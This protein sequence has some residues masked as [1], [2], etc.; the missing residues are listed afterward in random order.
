MGENRTAGDL[1]DPG[2]EDA[3]LARTLREQLGLIGSLLADEPAPGRVAGPTSAGAAATDGPGTDV[4]EPQPLPAPRRGRRA[5][6]TA[7][8]ASA[9]VLASLAGL[10]LL[11]HAAEP[12]GGGGDAKLTHEGIVACARLITQGTV[13]R[14]EPD[15]SGT[16]VVLDADRF[17]KPDREPGEVTFRVPREEAEGYRPGRRALVSVSRFPREGVDLYTGRDMGP[18]WAWMAAALPGSPTGPPCDGPG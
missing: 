16:R 13:T 2:A 4:T 3:E 18:A 9:V 1:P 12:G 10:G 15:G 8:A 5:V 14:T 17:L 7:L 6:L 11:R